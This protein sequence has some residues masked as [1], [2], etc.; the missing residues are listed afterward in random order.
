MPQ[1]SS[2]Y[3]KEVFD[4]ALKLLEECSVFYDENQACRHELT[5]TVATTI[6]QSFVKT[7]DDV[8]ESATT[9]ESTLQR[10]RKSKKKQPN[11]EVLSDVDKI[12][13]QLL[14]DTRAAEA[15]VCLSTL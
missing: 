8:L 12:K 2:L 10:I 15:T 5:T 14:L 1:Q 13:R 9:L 3:V 6:A 4:P 7:V 11:Q